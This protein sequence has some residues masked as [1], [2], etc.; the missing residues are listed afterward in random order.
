MH[1]CPFCWKDTDAEKPDQVIWEGRYCYVKY[2]IYPVTKHHC[3][4]IPYAHVGS[5]FAL[6]Q[7]E[8][9][10]M[11]KAMKW[12]KDYLHNK[13]RSISA[14][15]LGI[16]DGAAAGQTVPHCHLHVIPRREGDMEDPRG[17]VRGVIPH[18]Q[19]Y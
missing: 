13:D 3:L 14:F 16:N 15:N 9:Q 17:G 18:K 19:K 1:N 11:D 2:Y 5:Y 12:A 4:V 6:T 10:E 7:Q 8:H